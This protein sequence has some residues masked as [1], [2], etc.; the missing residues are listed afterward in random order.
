MPI[1][2]WLMIAALLAVC[3]GCGEGEIPRYAL[4]GAVL[5]D[6]QPVPV[7][8]MT[9]QPDEAA[10]N[11]GPA[12]Q[13]DIRDGRFATQPGQGT[14]GGPHVVTIFGF[15]GKPIAEPNNPAGRPM[16]TPIIS[17]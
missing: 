15:D 6:G 1:N 4:S 9:F 7:G 16:G 5:Y 11:S 13:A 10:G 17:G 14:I 3:V 12:T 8:Y 2:R